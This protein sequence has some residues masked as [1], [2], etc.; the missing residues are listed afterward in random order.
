MKAVILAGGEGCRLRPLTNHCPKPLVPILNKPVLEYSLELLKRHGI[1]D[2]I[3]TVHYLSSAIRSYFGDGSKWG[4]RITYSEEEMPLGTAGSV[5]LAEELLTEPFLVISGDILT[6]FD[7]TA[8]IDHHLSHGAAATIFT[9]PLDLP[10][11]YGVLLSKETHISRMFE[12]P[13]WNDLSD[14][15]INTGIY[16]F[17]PSIFS[18]LEEFTC[19]DFSNDLFPEMIRNKETISLFRADG[20]WSDIGTLSN[21]R[22]AQFDMLEHRVN[23]APRGKEI[24]KGIWMEDGV[25]IH[26]DVTLKGPIYISS[27]TIIHEGA[28]VGPHTVLS[29][30]AIIHEKS[31]VTHSILW[32]NSYIGKSCSLGGMIGQCQIQDHSALADMNEETANAW[33]EYTKK[34]S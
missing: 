26:D 21:Y 29:E 27:N 33:Q 11:E 17:N 19:S 30:S 14:H 24:A 25:T 1:D 4:I 10:I 9:K 15:S 23:L 12:K 22:E 34:N 5:K 13:K 6:D 32:E 28:T 3:M 7:L 18:Y 2:V 8:G 16:I 20:Y 31:S